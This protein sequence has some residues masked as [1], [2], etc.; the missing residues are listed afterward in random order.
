MHCGNLIMLKWKISKGLQMR[1]CFDCNGYS[2]EDGNYYLLMLIKGT[3]SYNISGKH[4]V[5]A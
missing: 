5:T 2:S 1:D 4:C 3:E